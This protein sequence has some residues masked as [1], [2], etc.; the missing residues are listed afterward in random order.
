MH[1]L[2]WPV[3][4]GATEP[5]RS[6]RPAGAPAAPFPRR[7]HRAATNEHGGPRP[8]SEN[9]SGIKGKRYR[10]EAH[11]HAS[12]DSDHTALSCGDGSTGVGAYRNRLARFC[13]FSRSSA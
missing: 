8:E 5:S 6:V 12:F 7:P 2:Y 11:P 3:A 13:R 4:A 10:W 9:A 1:N